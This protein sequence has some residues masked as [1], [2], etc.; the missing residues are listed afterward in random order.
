MISHITGGFFI[1]WSDNVQSFVISIF[2]SHFI[3]LPFSI[4]INSDGNYEIKFQTQDKYE[5]APTT[6]FVTYLIDKYGLSK[7][8]KGISS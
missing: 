4:Q 1:R 2:S 8:I 6:T 3:H 5:I 7:A